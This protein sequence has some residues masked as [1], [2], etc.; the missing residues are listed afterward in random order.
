MIGLRLGHTGGDRADAD[1]RDEFHRHVSARIDVLQIVDEL[2]QIF[3]RIDVMVRRR[4]DEA[5][6]L[7]RVAHFG[8]DGIDFVAGQLAALA[9]LAP[10]AIL[11]WIMSALTR[12]SAVAPKRPEATCL[13]AER[14]DRRS[15]T[16]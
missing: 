7:R 10:C 11:I 13:I 4:R 12:Y 16:A 8:D 9:G 14:I 3:D 6:A 5:D 1:F 2:L 15:A